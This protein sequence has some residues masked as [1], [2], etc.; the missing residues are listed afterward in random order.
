MVAAVLPLRG[1]PP[2]PLLAAAVPVGI[3]VY[4]GLVLLFDVAGLRSLAARRIRPR[5]A[6]AQQ[7]R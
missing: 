7:V 3:A 1:L 5:L 6:A 2:V 4:G